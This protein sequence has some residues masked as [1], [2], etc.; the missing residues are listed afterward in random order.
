MAIIIVMVTIVIREGEKGASMVTI[1]IAITI[2]RYVIITINH[3]GTWQ[4][5]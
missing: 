5:K 1:I 2:F 4:S 3:Y